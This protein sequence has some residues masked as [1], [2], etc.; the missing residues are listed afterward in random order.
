[1]LNAKLADRDERIAES[2]RRAEEDRVDVDKVAG[3]LTEIYLSPDELLKHVR[4]VG[5]DEIGENDFNLNIPRYVDTFEPE[6]P[7]S[8]KDALLAV[9]AA[10]KAASDAEAVLNCLLKDIGYGA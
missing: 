4:V 8:I 9:A 3:E 7:M 5:L 6:P 1:K 2:R 10:N